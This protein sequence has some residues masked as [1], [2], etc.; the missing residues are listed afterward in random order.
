MQ[1]K[2]IEALKQKKIE[3]VESL[4]AG[5]LDIAK[6]IL[7]TLDAKNEFY[8]CL[9]A[10][11][12]Y[13][14]QQFDKGI[15]KLEDGLSNLPY[16]YEITYNLASLNCAKEDYL[17]GFY[18]FARCI[19][20]ASND[21][22]KEE[23][24]NQFNELKQLIER[25]DMSSNDIKSIFENA[26]LILRE[27]DER[28]YPINRF[29]KSLVKETLMDAS[30]DEYFIEMYKSMHINN[31]DMNT[32]FFFKTELV[33]GNKGNLFSI[34]LKEK[35][36]LPIGLFDET[37]KI[38]VK[39]PNETY[40]Y[41]NKVLT[42]NQINYL[43]FEKGKYTIASKYPFF[44]G[45]PI[46]LKPIKKSPQIILTIFIDGLSNYVIKNRL[47]ELMPNTAEFFKD[48]YI[49]NNCTTTGDWT[50][51][52]VASIYTGKT[53]LKHSLYH[54]TNHFEIN[55]YNTL[56]TKSFKQSG[57][58]TSQINNNWR[59]TPTYGYFEDMDRILYQNYSGGFTAGE[60]VAETIEHLGTFSENNH[61]L[62]MGI[63]D[64]HD[65]ADE[66]NNDLMSQV[67]VAAQHRQ[68]KNIGVT[69]VLSKYDPNK[70]K[71][72]ESELKRIDLHLS[73]IYSY[74]GRNYDKENILVAI[75]SDHGQTYLKQDDYLLHEPK[76]EVPF[77]LVG[78]GIAPKVSNEVASILD[79][80][81]T[82][83][84]IAGV[85]IIL[86]EGV[87]LRDFGGKGREFSITE[88]IHPNQPYLVTITDDRFIFRFK[89]LDNLTGNGVI[90]LENYNAVLLDKQTFEDVKGI[91]PKKFEYYCEYVVNRAL[92]LQN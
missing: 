73:S 66:I 42:P 89:T 23:A 92:K 79:L 44:L 57:Y 8:Y 47:D 38:E 36:T 77:M 11:Y 51:P 20:L 54:P 43:T 27:G 82:I 90:N 29:Q 85:D 10:N 17:E 45:S 21:E 31:L 30:K 83:A 4:N 68:S 53:V 5:N 84:H 34:N 72:Y 60:V 7:D 1:S 74:L 55:K 49:N 63:E 28:T 86:Q 3:I 33:K 87:V 80:Y 69:S 56:F 14:S 76:R 64:L 65:V 70:I 62:W 26:K 12:Y 50:L 35:A 16:S 6:N 78:K 32:R 19:R 18:L 2:K 46:D 48:G 67:H 24:L 25:S 15:K 81:P 13:L 91:N 37:G 61:F 75:I 39:G 59:I 88:T 40:N 9:Y 58:M 22:Q 71:K 52:S 41:S